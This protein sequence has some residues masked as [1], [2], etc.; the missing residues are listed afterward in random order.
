LARVR[1][2][3]RR[4]RQPGIDADGIVQFGDIRVDLKVRLVTKAK[5]V[6]RLTP[7]EFRLLTVL[8]NNAERILRVLHVCP[9]APAERWGATKVEFIGV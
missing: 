1:A 9:G 4:Q 3:L 5:Q 6:V 7:T 2:T 8:V